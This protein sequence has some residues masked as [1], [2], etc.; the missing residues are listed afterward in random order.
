VCFE[1]T[2]YLSGPVPPLR[3]VVPGSAVLST[4]HAL[5]AKAPAPASGGLACPDDQYIALQY[6]ASYAGCEAKDDRGKMQ[7]TRSRSKISQ[8]LVPSCLE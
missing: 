1:V 2:R 5:T 3:G 6:L 8:S 4:I 7:D